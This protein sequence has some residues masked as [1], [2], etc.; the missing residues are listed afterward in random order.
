MWHPPEMRSFL[1]VLLAAMPGTVAWAE[2]AGPPRPAPAKVSPAQAAMT[3]YH[4]SY[5]PA[6]PPKPCQ[7]PKA[8]EIVVCALDGRGGSPDRLPLP[9]ERGA[10]AVRIVTGDADHMGVGD[11]PVR[12][13]RGTGLTLTL[14]ANKTTLKGNGQE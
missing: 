8:E 4:Q 11:S 9:G 1:L 12:N 13:P 2:T 10:P 3:N 14:K 5:D 6:A 7:R